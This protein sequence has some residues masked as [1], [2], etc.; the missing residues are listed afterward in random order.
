V[1]DETDKQA[2]ETVLQALVHEDIGSV[3]SLFRDDV[4]WWVPPSAAVKFDLP[5]PLSGWDRIPWL[6]GTGWR[7]FESGTSYLVIRHMIAEGG[8]V[9][10]YFNRTAKRLGGGD[11]DVEYSFLFRLVD[12][13]VAEIWEIADTARAFGMVR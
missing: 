9:S 11:Y 8:F 7:A 1:S 3:Q 6:G 13:Q 10:V 2:A 5:R 4:V 12:G